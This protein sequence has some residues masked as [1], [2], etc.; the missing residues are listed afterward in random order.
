MPPNHKSDASAVDTRK[1]MI[2]IKNN[3]SNGARGET[4]L[5]KR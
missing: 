3:K 1:K 5:E 4:S 2:M